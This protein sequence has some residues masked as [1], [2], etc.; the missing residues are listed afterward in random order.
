MNIIPQE[1]EADTEKLTETLHSALQFIAPVDTVHIFL[2]GSWATYRKSFTEGDVDIFIGVED[3]CY[4]ES[5]TLATTTTRIIP[6]HTTDGD[7]YPKQR[8]ELHW[9]DVTD[10]LEETNDWERIKLTFDSK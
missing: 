9:G 1:K 4:E 10:F 3:Y 7:M 8:I 6:I 5:P 2:F